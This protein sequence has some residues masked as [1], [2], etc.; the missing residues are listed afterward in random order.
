MWLNMLAVKYF[1]IFSCLYGRLTCT[2]NFCFITFELQ[3]YNP[4]VC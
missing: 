3:N 4:R 1:Y 2:G